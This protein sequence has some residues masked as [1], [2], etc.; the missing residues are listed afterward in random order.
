MDLLSEDNCTP[1]L[2]FF[3][4]GGVEYAKRIGD[5]G[6]HYFFSDWASFFDKMR[7]T[8]MPVAGLFPVTA[9][10]PFFIFTT[11]GS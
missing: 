4:L 10:R 3:F 8:L 7:Y 2:E 5:R 9:M 1:T 6:L 11:F